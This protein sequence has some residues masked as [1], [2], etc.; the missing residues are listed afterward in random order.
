M[1][2]AL[3]LAVLSLAAC[4]PF[5]R[6]DEVHGMRADDGDERARVLSRAREKM[7]AGEPGPAAEAF[8]QVL[9]LDPDPSAELLLSLAQARAAAGQRA[10]ARAAARLGLS[11]PQGATGT[12]RALRELLVRLYSDDALIEPALD[13]LPDPSLE[14]AL[15]VPALARALGPLADADRLA[16]AGKSDEALARYDE[17]LL[18]FGVPSHPLLVGFSEAVLKAGAGPAEQARLEA[19]RAQAEGRFPEAIRLYAL[20]FRFQTPDAFEAVTQA[21]FETAC[22][23]AGELGALTPPEAFARAQ[24]AGEA[25]RANRL[26]EALGG[27]RRAVALAP[28]WGEARHNL[29]LLL[30]RAEQY[31]EALRHMRAFLRL[32]GDSAAAARAQAL[33][34]DWERRADPAR[35][36][37]LRAEAQSLE[38]AV[39]SQRAGAR[40]W[41]DRG[42]VLMSA[43]ALAAAGAG[44]C[45][46]LGSQTNDRVRA[47]GFETGSDILL[48]A[49]V[50]ATYNTVGTALATTSAALLLVGLPI[51]LLNGD[52]ASPSVSAVAGPGFVGFALGGELP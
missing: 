32:S 22:A 7:A 28:W 46:A 8:G 45:A 27:Y 41:R 52:P 2:A 47:G 33:V 9:E 12:G 23:R 26:G 25:L 19:D 6:L 34:S 18:A 14:N 21:R 31:A 37:E 44:A 16:R 13:F 11:R 4:T 24:E 39:A 1:R 50:G 51:V 15:R 3:A 42:L 48:A 49:K 30:A 5:Y 36:G 38:S 10:A 35:K 29:A 20:A 43:G 17:W 40:A